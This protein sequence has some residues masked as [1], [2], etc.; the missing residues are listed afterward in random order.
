MLRSNTLQLKDQAS[1]MSK[2][3]LV[4]KN[5]SEKQRDL[6]KLQDFIKA[7]DI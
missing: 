6:K 2:K 3:A 5:Q 4:E 1:S 7:N